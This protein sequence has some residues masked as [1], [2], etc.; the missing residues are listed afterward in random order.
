MATDEKLI[1]CLRCNEYRSITQFRIKLVNPELVD[2]AILYRPRATCLVCQRQKQREWE[3]NRHQPEPVPRG[4]TTKVCVRCGEEKPLSEY[5][6]H[7]TAKWG[8]DPRCRECKAT[9]EEARQRRR[10]RTSR[11]HRAMITY[12]ISLEEWQ[13]LYNAQNKACAI[14]GTPRDMLALHIDHNH[15]T[16]MVRGLLCHSCNV[17]IGLAREKI[18]ILERAAVYL[19]AK[20]HNLDFLSVTATVHYEVK[21]HE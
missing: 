20:A 12:K 4:V 13:A 6:K 8:L 21:R 17:L 15:Q 9:G 19:F 3:A 14:C 2:P 18:I 11:E 10:E 7:K 16:G 1:L 5:Y